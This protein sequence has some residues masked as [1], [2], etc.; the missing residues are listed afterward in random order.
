MAEANILAYYAAAT[1]LLPQ[2]VLHH[3]HLMPPHF[4][5]KWSFMWSVPDGV[6]DRV[7]DD[8]NVAPV[9][10][11]NVALVYELFGV[12]VGPSDHHLGQCYNNFCGRN[13]QMFLIFLLSVTDRTH[14]TSLM[15]V[16]KARIE[17]S[18][19]KV[20]SNLFNSKHWSSW[21]G[22]PRTKTLDENEHS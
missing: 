8:S 20:G 22:L 1:I 13:L 18:T 12:A 11:Q 10:G 3:R 5:T 17:G 7:F 14:Q 4:A 16:Y 15:F 2:E 19:W 9:F 21:K 6:V